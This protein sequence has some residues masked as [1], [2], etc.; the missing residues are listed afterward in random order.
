M[1]KDI[2]SVIIPVY[3]GEKYL[4]ETLESVLNQSYKNLEVIVVDDGS[5]DKTALIIK[6][7]KTIKY[8]YQEN[9]GTASAFN[10]GIDNAIGKYFAFLGADD[11]WKKEKTEIQM[12]AFQKYPEHDIISGLVKQFL[13]PDLTNEQKD[14]IKYSK[15]LIPGHVIPAMLVK[16]DFFNRVGLF[17]PKWRVGAEMSWFLRARELPMKMMVLPKLVLLRRIHSSN[18]GITNKEFLSQRAQVIKAALDRRRGLGK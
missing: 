5:N 1:D 11:L 8:I 13:S 9:A 14:K 17:E 18:K 12:E 7:Y 2:V 16:K 6:N 3:N 10:N 15:E 4:S